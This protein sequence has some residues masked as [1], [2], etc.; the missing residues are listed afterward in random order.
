MSIR[1]EGPIGL[2]YSVEGG[3]TLLVGAVPRSS[4][5]ILET[6]SPVTGGLAAAIQ[7][8]VSGRLVLGSV[9]ALRSEVRAHLIAADAARQGCDGELESVQS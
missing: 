1:H 8:A 6:Y 7:E 9:E 5:E 2:L 4:G 3:T